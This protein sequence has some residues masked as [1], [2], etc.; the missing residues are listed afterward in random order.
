MTSASPT[1][2]LREPITL[3]LLDMFRTAVNVTGD[4]SVTTVMAATEG[5]K[6]TLLQKEEDVGN[7]DRG[8]EDRLDR[9]ELAQRINALGR[10]PAPRAP[11][12]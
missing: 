7:P 12:R 5:E 4:L 6:P 9:E 2:S 1:A 11:R 8:F 10:G 3:R